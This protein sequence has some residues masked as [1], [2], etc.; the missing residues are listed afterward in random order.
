H[1]SWREVLRATKGRRRIVKLVIAVV[2]VVAA[3]LALRTYVVAP[4]YIPSQS[5]E[6]TL[7][8]CKG[9]NDDHVLVDKLSYRFHQPHAGDIVVFDK[10]KK[11]PDDDPVLIKRVIGVGG[12]LLVLKHG[13]VYINGRRIKE[14][15][16]NKACPPRSSTPLTGKSRWQIPTDDVF[17]MG[18]NR[19]ESEDSRFFGP[20]PD[21]SIIG[22]AFVIVWPLK[23]F[24]FL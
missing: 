12:D 22:R 20:I 21:S 14:P 2:V 9:C 16:I 4:Y 19:C 6:P 8:G 3:A 1:R 17:V 18:D 11:L 5:M 13:L 7:H 10:P 23:R 24:S 15:Y